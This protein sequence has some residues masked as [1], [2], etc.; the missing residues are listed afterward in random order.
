MILRVNARDKQDIFSDISFTAPEL[1]CIS[2]HSCSKSSRTLLTDVVQATM[3]SE[4]Q[5]VHAVLSW[6][7][8]SPIS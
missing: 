3:V 4:A 2:T 1:H 7:L 8:S 6:A 5:H